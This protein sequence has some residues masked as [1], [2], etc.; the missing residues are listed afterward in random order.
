MPELICPCDNS[1]NTEDNLQMNMKIIIYIFFLS[2][3][4]S[5]LSAISFCQSDANFEL[6]KEKEKKIWD[7]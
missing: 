6:K 5:M 1:E 4:L 3:L 2:S 7:L